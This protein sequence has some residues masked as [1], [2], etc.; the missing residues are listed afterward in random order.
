MAV[1]SRG[2]SFSEITSKVGS[3]QGSGVQL[4]FQ[5]MGGIGGH[6]TPRS[7]EAV[8]SEPTATSPSVR[9][10][11]PGLPALRLFCS[12]QLVQL[13]DCCCLRFCSNHPTPLI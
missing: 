6:R 12:P 8:S 11:P 3:Q 2:G 4:G 7:S 1:A 13:P 9:T 10:P 5:V